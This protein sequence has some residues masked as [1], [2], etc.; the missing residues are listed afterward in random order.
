METLDLVFAQ[1]NMSV[2]VN[3]TAYF[4]NSNDLGTV[5]GFNVGNNI[6]LIGN[7]NAISGNTIT[8]QLEGPFATE[9]NI[10]GSFVLFSKD[11]LV[12]LNTIKGYYA[13]ATFKNNSLEKAELYATACDIEESS[14]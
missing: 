13:Q 10:T 7:I 6:Q 8:V 4:V 2:Q 3:D 5:G 1:L 9:E 14:E 11:N 12:E